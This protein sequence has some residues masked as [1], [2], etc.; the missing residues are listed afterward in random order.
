MENRAERDLLVTQHYYSS[1]CE[2]AVA[3]TR[4]HQISSAAGL[5]LSR[6]GCH[7]GGRWPNCSSA[8]YSAGIGSW[9]RWSLQGNREWSKQCIGLWQV[10]EIGR[11]TY[12]CTA[13][14]PES[15]SIWCFN[16][17]AV[18]LVCG[19]R[20]QGMLGTWDEATIISFFYSVKKL[21]VCFTKCQHSP[22]MIRKLKMGN[23]FVSQFLWYLHN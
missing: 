14:C 4:T 11:P 8:V 5:P 10:V 21:I 1:E 22:L 23:R 7:W 19:A 9:N 13:F 18:G 3:S 12:V 6:G 15:D 20:R 16:Q 17:T 2:P